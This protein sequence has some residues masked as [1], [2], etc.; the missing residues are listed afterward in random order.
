MKNKSS[1]R[2]FLG[3]AGM[4]GVAVGLGTPRAFAEAMAGEAASKSGRAIEQRG[5]KM[6]LRNTRHVT[7]DYD[8]K[9]YC[10]H[11]RQCG[12]GNFGGELAVLYWRAQCSYGTEKDVTDCLQ[13]GLLNRGEVVLRRSRDH[14]ET[15]PAQS[16]VIVW[17]NELPL[18]KRAEFLC[19]D[20]GRREVLDMGK[21]EAMFFFGRTCIRVAQSVKNTKQGWTSELR[22]VEPK[23]DSRKGADAAFCTLFQMRSVDKGQTWERVPLVFGAPSKGTSL[24]K[25]NHPLVTMPDGALVG[26]MESE[27]ALWLYGSECQGMTW[28]YLSLIAME[29][30][31]VGKPSCAG[32]VL[33]PSGRLQCYM[34][35]GDA[36]CVAESD[37][38]FS[39]SEPRPIA[40]QCHGPWPLR[41][42]DGRTVVVFARRQ[43]P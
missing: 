10:G 2:R 15:W 16:E 26:A 35:K 37:N 7:V 9:T 4:L 3:Q 29:K 12:I 11:P 1:R 8:K 28:Q 36:M 34:L 17:S 14:G 6:N 21:P 22:V 41:L 13:D 40:S 20:P 38:C 33:L 31:D 43:L 32:L 5:K 19:Q 25:D 42:C 39:W 27:G 24:W 18:E 30:P 23:G